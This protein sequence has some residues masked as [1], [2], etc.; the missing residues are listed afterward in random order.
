MATSTI[1]KLKLSGSTNGRPIKVIATLTPGT[2]IHTA[3]N[4]ANTLDEVT[5]YATNTSASD[6]ALTIEQGGTT[7]PDD[8]LKFIIPAGETVQVLPGVVLD[9]GVLCRA[10]A[11]VANVVNIVGF[12]HRI[13]QT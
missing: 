11:A 3:T 6:V 7:S 13:V 9:G 10:F 1:T 4:A 8:L 5:A 12:V 2:T